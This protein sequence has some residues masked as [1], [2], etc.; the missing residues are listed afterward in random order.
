MS[1]LLADGSLSARTVGLLA[2]IETPDAMESYLLRA[3]GQDDAKRRA[4]R[5]SR[6]WMEPEGKRS[7]RLQVNVQASLKAATM[8][9]RSASPPPTLEELQS[10]LEPAPSK[11]LILSK[12]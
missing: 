2:L 8:A 11:E 12:A 6:P 3:R 1:R 4:Q 9:C 5:C 7:P 10:R